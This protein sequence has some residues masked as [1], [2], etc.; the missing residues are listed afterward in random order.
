MSDASVRPARPAD[1]EEIGRIQDAVFRI[2]Y[3]DLLAPE[4]VAAFSP[5]AFAGAWREAISAPPSP[6][7][8]L[9]VATEGDDVVGFLAAAP[10]G[11]TGVIEVL[12][13][14]VHPGRQGTGHGSRLLNA[15]ADLARESGIR[16]LQVWT[17]ADDERVRAFLGGAGFGP[18]GSW[19]D[20]EVDP[21]GRTV[22]EVRLVTELADPID[23]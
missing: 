18:D 5:G 3:A 8:R 22:R 15:V 23:E 11:E 16:R 10:A 17:L 14:G 1:V 9:L 7:H 21:D 2:A 13:G 20:R 19:R 6:Q 4:V 12:T